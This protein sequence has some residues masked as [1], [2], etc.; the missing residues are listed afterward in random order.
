MPPELRIVIIAD[1]PLAR[2]GL[3]AHL[4]GEPGC[5]VIGQAP[6]DGE[7][8]LAL[9]VYRPDA[10]LWDLGW[11]PQRP[12]LPGGKSALEQLTDLERPQIPIVALLPDATHAPALWAA[13]VRSLLFRDA[14]PAVIVA[15]LAAA[16]AGLV[17]LDP[18]LAPARVVPGERSHVALLE[19]LTPRELDVLRC[20]A[21]GLPNK[22]I[23]RQ[24][25]ISEHTV[26]FHVNAILSKLGAQ[27]RTEAVVRA[28]R[29]GLIN[30]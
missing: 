28:T 24:L 16:A 15:A 6:A 18:A 11:D 29:L 8:A 30:L 7:L 5:Q 26:K 3:A 19:E 2:M 1:D 20:L 13:A 12:A 23:A 9:A 14:A 27:G 10:A 17:V 25:A 21:E 4:A 22:E